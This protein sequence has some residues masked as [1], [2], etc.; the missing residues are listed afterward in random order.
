MTHYLY[1]L[2]LDRL[3]DQSSEKYA[4]LAALMMPGDV[5]IHR[6]LLNSYY[7][8]NSLKEMESLYSEMSEFLNSDAVAN[9]IMSC[10]HQQMGSIDKAI[11]FAARSVELEPENATLRSH[12]NTLASLNLDTP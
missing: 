9:Y 6:H 4:K 7:R 3:D 5:T 8:K 11:K 1:S 12:L 10:G 2:V